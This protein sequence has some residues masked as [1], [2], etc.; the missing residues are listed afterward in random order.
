MVG[1]RWTLPAERVS[2]SF[3]DAGRADPGDSHPIMNEWRRA[4]EVP[5]QVRVV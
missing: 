2:F 4:W 5:S 3:S 1:L